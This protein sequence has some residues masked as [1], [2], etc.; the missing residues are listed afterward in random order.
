MKCNGQAFCVQAK[1][2]WKLVNHKCVK[3]KPCVCK[4]G[5]PVAN[6]KK[7]GTGTGWLI[8]IGQVGFKLVSS[9]GCLRSPFVTVFEFVV[10][11]KFR[12]CGAM[13]VGQCW[14]AF[15]PQEMR[16]PKQLRQL[17]WSS[18]FFQFSTGCRCECGRPVANWK[19]LGTGTVF[20]RTGRFQVSVKVHVTVFE[21]GKNS[22]FVVRAMKV[23]QF[24]G[25]EVVV[26]HVLRFFLRKCD[27]QNNCD[28]CNIECKKVGGIV[29][30]T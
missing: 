19:K 10:G 22:G 25:R 7:L 18:H 4:C 1:P 9:T 8:R 5:R 23:V 16:R 15:P 30:Y 26:H 21:L 17:F 12:T 29:A 20:I 24:V 3:K 13:K 14:Y 11:K 2:G 6:W 27:G 28:K